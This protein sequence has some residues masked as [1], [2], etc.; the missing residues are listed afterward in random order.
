MSKIG[1]DNYVDEGTTYMVKALHFHFVIFTHIFVAFGK[2][3]RMIG[4]PYFF[5]VLNTCQFMYHEKNVQD[6][7]NSI[8]SSRRSLMWP[9]LKS[10]K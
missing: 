2:G 5:F 7:P 4:H 9:L 8:M 1:Q 6:W 10:V 3:Q